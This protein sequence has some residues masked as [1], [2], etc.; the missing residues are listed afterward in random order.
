MVDVSFR[1]G[2][3]KLDKPELKIMMLKWYVYCFKCFLIQTVVIS[4]VIYPALIPKPILSTKHVSAK[5]FTLRKFGEYL[6]FKYKYFFICT[7]VFDIHTQ[8]NWVDEYSF[9]VNLVW[10]PYKYLLFE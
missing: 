9:C 2:I 5:I 10:I 7:N 3:L 1:L 4:F 8:R 6:K